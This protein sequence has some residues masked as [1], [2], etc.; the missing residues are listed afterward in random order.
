MCS[1][2]ALVQPKNKRAPPQKA[3]VGT[4]IHICKALTGAPAAGLAVCM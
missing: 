1:N 3:A 2:E 4:T